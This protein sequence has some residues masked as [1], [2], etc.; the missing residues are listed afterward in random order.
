MWQPIV[1]TYSSRENKEAKARNAKVHALDMKTTTEFVYGQTSHV[2]SSKRNLPKVLQGLVAGKYIVTGEFLDAVIDVATPQNTDPENYRASKLEEDFDTWWPKEKEYIPLA[3]V[4]PVTRP[5]H[6]LLPNADRA[7]VFSGLTFVFLNEAQYSSLQDPIA[8]GSGKA[9]L[10]PLKFGETTIDEYVEFVR[11][12]AGE[13]R[14]GR[15]NNDRLPVITVR[16]SSFPDD[17]EAW[18]TAFV[19]GV[20]QALNQRSIQQNEFLDAI[21]T[22]DTSSLQRPP[23]EI[24]VDSSMPERAPLQSSVQESVPPSQPRVTSDIPDSPHTAA[25]E[26]P[27]ANPRKRPLRRPVTQSRFTGFDDYEPPSKTRRIETQ[28]EAS[29]EDVKVSVP[30]QSTNVAVQSSYPQSQ[31]PV[32]SAP[33]TQ[34]SHPARSQ[35]IETVEEVDEDELFPAAAAIKRRRAATR[36]ISASVEPEASLAVPEPK[37]K[38][39]KVLE[40]LQKAKKKIGKDIDVREQTKQLMQAQEEKRR[41]DEESLREALQGVDISEIRGLVQVEEMEIKPRKGGPVQRPG[42]A[43]GDRWNDDWNGRKNFKKFRRKGAERGPLPQKILV[44]FEEVPSKKGNGFS[45]A[46]YL[47]EPERSSR[48]EDH[49]GKR[50]TGRIQAR[51]S[52]SEPES[53]FTRRKRND[54]ENEREVINVEDSEPDVQEDTPE[55]SGTSRNRTQ[56]VV[57][58]QV[59]VSQS[60]TQTQRKRAPLSV[61]AGQPPSKRTRVTRPDDDSDAEETGFRFKRRS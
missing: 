41:A 55:A 45:D 9:L 10:F 46:F 2:V 52:E 12:T 7:D 26:A 21:I 22:N 19:T 24:E 38:G 54:R 28:D 34:V 60:Q 6:Y 17:M 20:D 58:T 42:G 57:E 29:M 53:G 15:T 31:P 1:F 18:A 8:G 14:R 36:G 13:K 56:R 51:D 50:K 37:T 59:R 23:P 33:S 16:L 4:E 25:G 30:T 61:A 43:S 44:G 49:R 3:G 39:E 11:N 40:Q 5:E 32:P 47:E 27:R 35:I 48:T